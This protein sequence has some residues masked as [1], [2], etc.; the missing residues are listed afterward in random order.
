[1]IEIASVKRAGCSR[2]KIPMANAV[3]AGTNSGPYGGINRQWDLSQ[4]LSPKR[5]NIVRGRYGLV[6]VLHLGSVEFQVG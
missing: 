3:A 2:A 1:M 6:V 5:S 4:L